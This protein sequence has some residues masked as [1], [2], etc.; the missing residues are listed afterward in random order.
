MLLTRLR[1]Y[2]FRSINTT[3]LPIFQ[4]RK[5]KLFVEEL[6]TGD[7]IIRTGASHE[8]TV[9]AVRWRLFTSNRISADW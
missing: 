2:R 8:V 9:G 5:K 4:K 6:D 1:L 7:Q 3:L